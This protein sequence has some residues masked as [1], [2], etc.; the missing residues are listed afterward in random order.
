MSYEL[1]YNS[2]DGPAVID[3]EGRTL[4]GHEFGA[5]EGD[6]ID[7]SEGALIRVTLPDEDVNPDAADAQARVDKLNG[8]AP[9]P[10]AKPKTATPSAD[11]ADAVIEKES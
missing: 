5:V 7:A 11:E 4:G 10:K 9:K 6:R 1:A 8:V 3:D 2:T